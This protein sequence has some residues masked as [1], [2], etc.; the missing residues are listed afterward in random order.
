M[1][2][3]AL[4]RAVNLGARNKVPM[5]E[6]RARLEAA[7]YE[8]VRTFIASG[9]VLLDAP[10]NRAAVAG[11]LERLIADAFR[12][13]TTAIMRTPDELAAVVAGHPFGADTAHSHV[14]FLAAEPKPDAAERF[15]AVDPTPDRAVLA[16]ANVYLQY[17]AGVQGSRLSAARLERLLEVRATHRNWRTVA[18]LAELAAEA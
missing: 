12:V 1:R 5:A 2:W 10:K 8:G 7:G 11:K 4:L 6:L 14:V 16:G 17:P 18:K 9:N 15:E 3:V 13:E